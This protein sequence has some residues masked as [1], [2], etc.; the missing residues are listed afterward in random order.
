[1]ITRTVVSTKVVAM[2]V[3]TETAEV[4]NKEVELPGTF[5]KEKDLEKALVKKL[6]TGFEKFVQVCSNEEEVKLI[7]KVDKLYGM[8]EEEFISF[9]TLLDPKTRKPMLKE[10]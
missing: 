9:A 7:E 5:K 2:C 4:F 1:M 10:V 8:E 3:N 6:N